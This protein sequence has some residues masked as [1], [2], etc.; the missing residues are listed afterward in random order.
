MARIVQLKDSKGDFIYPKIAAAAIYMEDGTSVEEKFNSIDHA[1]SSIEDKPAL[2]KLLVTLNKNKE[3]E[4]Q[5]LVSREEYIAPAAPTFRPASGSG[6]G[7]LD[8]S[9]A[10]ATSGA[11]IQYKVDDDAWTIGTSVTLS[12]DT[13]VQSKTYT[14][15]AKAV[16]ND[17]ESAVVSASYTVNR[18]VAA[19]T[20]T[21]D[22]SNKYSESRSV[23]ISCSTDG[24]TIHYTT[25][26]SNPT[27]SSPTIASGGTLTLSTKGTFTVKAMAF[28]SNWVNSLK[29]SKENIIVGAGKCYIGQAESVTSEENI[30]ALANSYEYDTLVG[31]T[32]STINFGTNTQYVWF[33]IP[34]TKRQSLTVKSDGF[35]VT[36]DNA[37]GTVIEGYRVWRT[38]NKINSNFTFQ[39]T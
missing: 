7:S 3:N 14:V 22:S 35:A 6:D 11:K 30:K 24:A 20:I 25:D 10:S 13:S 38:A 31:Q 26:G 21:M 33:A 15:Y 34:S 27:T 29:A 37:D 39:F 5:Y 12:Q 28:L 8:V 1:G 9:I 23:T 19:P 17:M 2:G 32:V 36:L 4:A 16:K 18:R